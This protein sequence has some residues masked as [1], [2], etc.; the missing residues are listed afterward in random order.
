MFGAMIIEHIEEF[1]INEPVERWIVAIAAF[2]KTNHS[3]PC[4][5]CTEKETWPW[6]NL[7]AFICVQF[8][9]TSF[10]PHYKK[11]IPFL[12]LASCLWYVME[13]F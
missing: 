1:Q 10:A 12:S 8:F 9:H 6:F 2:H 7:V 3:I 5:C 4:G 13:D 11:D